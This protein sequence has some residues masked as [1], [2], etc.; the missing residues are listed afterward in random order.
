MTSVARLQAAGASLQLACKA[1]GPNVVHD[2]VQVQEGVVCP[3]IP[4]LHPHGKGMLHGLNQVMRTKSIGTTKRRRELCMPVI[5][6]CTCSMWH[7][8]HSTACDSH[9]FHAV[10]CALDL[11]QRDSPGAFQWTRNLCMPAI[12]STDDNQKSSQVSCQAHT[13]QHA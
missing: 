13:C 12:W 5:V 8:L 4:Q 6:S 3:W 1:H 11:S 9:G 2:I 7:Q 10:C